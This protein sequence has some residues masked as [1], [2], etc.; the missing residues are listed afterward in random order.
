MWTVPCQSLKTVGA[1]RAGIRHE[2]TSRIVTQVGEPEQ[3][4]G[5]HDWL[6]G[7]P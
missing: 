1:K 6:H 2:R 3:R 7:P 5:K 4:S